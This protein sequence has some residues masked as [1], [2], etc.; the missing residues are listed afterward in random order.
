MIIA[1]DGPAGSGKTTIGRQLG[2]RLGL[3]VVDTGLMYRAVT[4][5][6]RR[7][8][9]AIDDVPALSALARSARIRLETDPNLPRNA[10]LVWINGRDV[11]RQASSAEIAHDLIQVAQIHGVRAA[12]VKRQRA[13]GRGGVVMLGR[14]IGTV[15][16]PRAPHKFFL[17][18]SAHERAERRKRELRPD[19]SPTLLEQ[20]VNARD[21]ADSERAIAPLRPAPDA[22]IVETEGKSVTEVCEEVLAHLPARRASKK[23]IPCARRRRSPRY[24]RLPA[25]RPPAL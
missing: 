7:R 6:A 2:R 11:T 22:V 12:L 25:R 10:P 18:A 17:T 8:H 5:E 20:E 15:V 24:Q 14:D 1:I 16:L 9:I 23:P 21:R 3:A 4:I 19:I 13:L